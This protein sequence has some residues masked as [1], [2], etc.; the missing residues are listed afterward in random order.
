MFTA[1]CRKCGQ[2]IHRWDDRPA[3]RWRH[4]DYARSRGCRAATF[5]RTTG[6]DDSVS[7]SWTAEPAEGTVELDRNMELTETVAWSVMRDEETNVGHWVGE[8][9]AFD[10]DTQ[11]DAEPVGR[12]EAWVVTHATIE[13]GRLV[14]AVD[15]VSHDVEHIASEVARFFDNEIDI[16]LDDADDLLIW[17][18]LLILDYIELDPAVRG[19]RGSRM[20]LKDLASLLPNVT[21]FALIP[22]DE[23]DAVARQK[24]TAMWA[25]L[26]F[27]Q[28]GDSDV[29]VADARKFRETNDDAI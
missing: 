5:D 26:G 1:T 16:S 9:Q 25:G 4:D 27:V 20:V 23:R 8:V 13:E 2:P 28:V 11:N 18:D 19:Q 29:Y 6:W 22:G 17:G 24:L 10:L 12:V 15:D 21:T 3:S 7:G 14:W